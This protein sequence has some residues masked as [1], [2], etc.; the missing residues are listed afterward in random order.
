LN[1]ELFFMR[2]ATANY[3][4][5]EARPRGA[6]P[7]V[8]AVIYP[9]DLDL[10]M[11]GTG[12]TFVNTEYIGAQAGTP[13]PRLAMQA[14][15]FLTGSWVSPVMQAY[16]PNLVVPSWVDQAGYMTVVVSIRT[17]ATYEGVAGAAWTA[18][19]SGGEYDLGQYY[20][21]KVELISAIRAWAVDE[22]G[23]ADAYSAYAVDVSPDPGYD[24]Y[25]SDGEF[26]GNLQDFLLTGKVLLPESE[27]HNPG[28]VSLEMSLDFQNL[29]TGSNRLVVDNRSRQWIPGGPNFYLRAIPWYKKQLK[30]Y[31]GYELG[32]RA[33]GPPGDRRLHPHHPGQKDR[34]AGRGRHQKAFHAGLLPGQGGVDRHHGRGL[35]GGEDRQRRGQPARGGW[36]QI[37]RP[38]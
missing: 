7:R 31:H 2:E 27:I 12:G 25:A 1:F 15:Y 24:S 32:G 16:T 11:A 20:Q 29:R 17:A 8:R 5:E 3:L 34:G 14:G 38:L 22:A 37:L 30:L 10:G 4:Q 13:A 19:A 35:H 33:P 28:D 18:V 9:F 6:K 21:V 23:D 36:H 26:P